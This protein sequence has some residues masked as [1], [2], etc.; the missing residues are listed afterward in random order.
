[1]N[2]SFPFLRETTKPYQNEVIY[3]VFFNIDRQ[4]KICRNKNAEISYD[5]NSRKQKIFEFL[6]ILK[7]MKLPLWAY[8]LRIMTNYSS[9]NIDKNKN[10]ILRWGQIILRVIFII[11]IHSILFLYFSVE[12]FFVF[13]VLANETILVIA[14]LKTRKD[15]HEIEMSKVDSVKKLNELE[16]QKKEVVLRAEN[17]VKRWFL[18]LIYIFLK[19][20]VVIIE[21]NKYYLVIPKIIYTIYLTS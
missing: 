19:K 5:N 18:F 8:Y 17:C 20:L 21:I 16:E 14:E 9:N 4:L 12:N 1:M 2:T 7:R 3:Y 15:N 13:V 11:L 10:I 6:N